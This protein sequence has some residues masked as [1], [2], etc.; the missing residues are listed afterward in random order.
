MKKRE[1]KRIYL[2]QDFIACF[3]SILCHAMTAGKTDA[4]PGFP[5]FAIIHTSVLC[6][7]EERYTVC[8]GRTKR[9]R[10]ESGVARQ[11]GDIRHRPRLYAI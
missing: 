2:L 5:V 9:E 1:R 7:R 11:F 8:T 10:I 3:K 4:T 6:I